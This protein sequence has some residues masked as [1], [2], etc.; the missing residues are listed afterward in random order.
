MQL[1]KC[2]NREYVRLMLRYN[3]YDTDATVESM[4]AEFHA[5]GNFIFSC[6]VHLCFTCAGVFSYQEDEEKEKQVDD[7]VSV[8]DVE[9]NLPEMKHVEHET[10]KK[11]VQAKVNQKIP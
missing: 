7:V 3:A 10:K 9:A 2:E 5:N 6:L 8:K 11:A 1:T 4:L